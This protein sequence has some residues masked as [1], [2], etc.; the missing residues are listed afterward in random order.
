MKK[1]KKIG[2][3]VL[4]CALTLVMCQSYSLDAAI[5]MAQAADPPKPSIVPTVQKTEGDS[6]INLVDNLPKADW[7]ALVSQTIQL[8]LGI[9][10]TLTLISFTVGGVMMLTAMGN[11]DKIN[12]GKD[13]LF[14]SIIALVI[15]AVSYAAVLGVSKLLLIQPLQ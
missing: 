1:R 9:S 15:I 7:R 6:K 5:P 11:E 2:L 3:L 8:I 10:G 13:V 14:W 4:L 12:K